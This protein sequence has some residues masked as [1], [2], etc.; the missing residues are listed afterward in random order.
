ME[1]KKIVVHVDYKRLK[2][3]V[4]AG[5]IPSLVFL[6]DSIDKEHFPETMEL[7]AKAFL[8]VNI[9]MLHVRKNLKGTGKDVTPDDIDKI[10]F[11]KFNKLDI[12]SNDKEN[13]PDG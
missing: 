8:P 5:M 13:K 4:I 12:K 3:A 6:R 9:W 7:F 11:P 2:N 10:I 1:A